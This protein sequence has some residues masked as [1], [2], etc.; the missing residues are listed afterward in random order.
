MSGSPDDPLPLTRPTFAEGF[1]T[2]ARIGCLSFGGAVRQ[3]ALMHREFVDDRRWIDEAPFSPRAQFPSSASRTGGAAACGLGPVASARL[4]RRRGGGRVAVHPGASVMLGLSLLY[5]TAAGLDWF[6]VLLT[7]MAFVLLFR[8]RVG[9]LSLLA[10]CS[11]GGL[12]LGAG[13]PLL[14]FG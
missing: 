10:I 4:S 1:R 2:Y 8:V 5:V 12:L 7:L 11:V 14:D 3:I 9:I 13:G 6:A